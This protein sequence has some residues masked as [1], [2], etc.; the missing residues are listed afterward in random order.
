MHGGTAL[1]ARD[2]V[3]VR[4]A[5]ERSGISS[6]TIY[7]WV[8]AEKMWSISIGGVIFVHRDDVELMAMERAGHA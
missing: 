6:R 8:K 7:R 5:A 3:G 4:E 1:E 2:L